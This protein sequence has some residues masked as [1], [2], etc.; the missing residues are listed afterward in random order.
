MPR[1]KK[2]LFQYL[3]VKKQ[4]GNLSSVYAHLH[5]EPFTLPDLQGNR[6]KT[7]VNFVYLLQKL[8]VPPLGREQ[9]YL[10]CQ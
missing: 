8:N 9:F 3:Y 7:I 10:C 1:R 2:Y 4:Q 5:K 6:T